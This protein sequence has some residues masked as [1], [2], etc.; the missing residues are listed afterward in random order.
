MIHALTPMTIVLH[1]GTDFDQVMAKHPKGHE[2]ILVKIAGTVHGYR[3]SCPHIGIGLD[4]GN[5]KCQ[6]G[7]NELTCSMHGAQFEADTGLCFS[8]PCEGRSL[9]RIAVRV[10]NGHVVCD[11]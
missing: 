5:G 4:Y 2:I 10:E 11:E 8:G 7:Q 3:N 6:S 1:P 9:E